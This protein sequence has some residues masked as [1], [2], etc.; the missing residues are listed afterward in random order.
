MCVLTTPVVALNPAT[1]LTRLT[2]NERLV[3]RTVSWTRCTVSL[4]RPAACS[5]TAACSTSLLR[6]NRYSDSTTGFLYQ[7]RNQRAGH[8]RQRPLPPIEGDLDNHQ[9][10]SSTIGY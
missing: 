9:T 8:H 10:F 4:S 7:Q 1:M 5:S 2:R 3:P 6:N